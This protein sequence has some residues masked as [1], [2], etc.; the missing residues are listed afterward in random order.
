[1]DNQAAIG[2]FR[3]VSGVNMLRNAVAFGFPARVVSK[4]S[5]RLAS[6]HSFK[7]GTYLK[8]D[9]PMAQMMQRET[10]I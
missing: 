5:A 2:I 3:S 4:F 8:L 9:F 7:P 6:R 1:M 10:A